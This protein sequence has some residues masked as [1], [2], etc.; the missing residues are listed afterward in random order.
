M[1]APQRARFQGVAQIVRFNWTFYA[2]AALLLM[3]A[4]F[5]I[6][7]H[8]LPSSVRNIFLAGVALAAFW[9]IMSLAVAYYVYDL[10][11]IYDGSWIQRSLRTKPRKWATFHAGL[12][13]FSSIL[14][15]LFA[16]SEGLVIDLFDPDEM[17]ESSIRRARQSSKQS[18]GTIH[19][20]FRALP[21]PADELDA[22]FLFFCAHELRKSESRTQFFKELGRITGTHGQMILLEHLRDWPNFLAFGPGCF[23]FHSRRNWMRAIES[24]GFTVENEFRFTPFVRAFVLGKSTGN[25]V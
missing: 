12:D 20:N 10:A 3:A 2:T 8:S 17:T 14:R 9:L 5:I 21:L 13:E 7:G 4:S 18:K 1:T 11:A 19:A 6:L 24:G 16:D 25:D 15:D 23:H 22:V